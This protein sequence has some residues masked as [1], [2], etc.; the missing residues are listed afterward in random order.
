MQP[1]T[2][3]STANVLTIDIPP[4]WY[5]QHVKGQTSNFW[6]RTGCRY[7]PVTNRAQCETGACGEK[8]PHRRGLMGRDDRPHLD[9]GLLG[10]A[11]P[12]LDVLHR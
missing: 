4:Q 3:G 6:A 9:D 11:H 5:G 1:Y 2:P 8:Y 10:D 7:D 12:V